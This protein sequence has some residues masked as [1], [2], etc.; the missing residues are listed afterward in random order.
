MA[1][2]RLMKA[3]INQSRRRLKQEFEM[4]ACPRNRD[5]VERVNTNEV[6]A[7]FADLVKLARTQQVVTRMAKRFIIVSFML[8]SS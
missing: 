7:A 3:E 8:L 6:L 2:S 4:V 1:Q 5:G